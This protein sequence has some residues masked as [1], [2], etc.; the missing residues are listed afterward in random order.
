MTKA[1]K[2]KTKPVASKRRQLPVADTL[3]LFVGIAGIASLWFAISYVDAL[4]FE[5]HAATS[6]YFLAEGTQPLDVRKVFDTTP[7]VIS[8]VT[9]TDIGSNGASIHWITDE[10]ATA[11]V[12]YGRTL[13]YGSVSV[14]KTRLEQKHAIRIFGLA[15]DTQYYYE[16]SSRDHDSNLAS[17]FGLSFKT[18]PEAVTAPHAAAKTGVPTCADVTVEVASSAKRGTFALALVKALEM[19]PLVT[20]RRLYTDV[21]VTHPVFQSVTTLQRA[22]LM[23]GYSTKGAS[24]LFGTEDA[25]TPATQAIV[26]ARAQ[27]KG[28]CE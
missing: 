15:P 11:Q 5:I 27:K 25:I 22:G 3:A 21:P 26:I 19:K 1:R 12:R 6:Q 9:A 4:S 17:A 13:S 10:F 24:R 16:V 28:L 18:L 2:T 20:T 7:P 14:P 8:A 23:Q